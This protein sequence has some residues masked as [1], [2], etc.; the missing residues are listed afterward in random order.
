MQ[1]DSPCL[2]GL[3]R[4]KRKITETILQDM[5][6]ETPEATTSKKRFQPFFVIFCSQQ[7]KDENVRFNTNIGKMFIEIAILHPLYE[8]ALLWRR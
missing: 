4:E 3:K 2:Y 1:N 6:P 7:Q 5:E 8:V